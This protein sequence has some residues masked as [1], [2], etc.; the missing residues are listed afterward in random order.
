[1]TPREWIEPGIFRRSGHYE[2]MVKVRGKKHSKTL[3]DGATLRTARAERAKL[4]TEA[5]KGHAIAPARLRVSGLLD[6][7]LAD[8]GR[9][10]RSQSTVR[11]YT[12][13]ASYWRR[14]IGDIK[15]RDLTA[16]DIE[17]A[18]D[19]LLSSLLNPLPARPSTTRA[20]ARKTRS[21]PLS[22]KSVKNALGALNI[23]LNWAVRHDILARN[24]AQDVKAPA[25][26]RFES[27][28]ASQEE[29]RRLL[30]AFERNGAP[31]GTMLALALLTCLRV[32][33]EWGGMRWRDI[34]LNA[35]S[36]S[37]TR[38]RMQD[39]TVV[40]AG[41]NKHK[42]R[43]IPLSDEAVRFLKIQQRWQ[44]KMRDANRGGWVDE[45]GFV[46][47]THHGERI[48]QSTLLRNFDRMLTEA[49]VPRMRV[50]DLRHTGATLLLAAGVHVKV[51]S[52]LLG[53]S[54]IKVT[55][56]TYGH[57]VPGLAE[58]AADRLGQLLAPPSRRSA[59]EPTKLRR[60][61]RSAQ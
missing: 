34:D 5:S 53:H 57:A 29:A 21:R 27:H 26:E 19:L 47:T 9:T 28:W 58:A 49:N 13:E 41:N 50:H 1:M 16:A 30:A 43:L 52:E 11:A 14:T 45:E 18:R 22:A 6:A 37:L 23:A 48:R 46:F 36:A 38:A 12:L 35:K 54:S 42:R 60:L 61:K 2:V 8:I 51:L 3:P 24:V 17:R 44:T 31:Y 55:L 56:D 15:L 7:W 39:G 40:P 25:V 59:S 10:A 33:S 20:R 4:V 32:E